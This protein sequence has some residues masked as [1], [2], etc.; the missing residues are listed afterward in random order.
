MKRNKKM[1]ELEMIFFE[2]LNISDEEF[3]EYEEVKLNSYRNHSDMN[4]LNEG[5]K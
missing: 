4:I 1:N 2:E 5:S 3:K